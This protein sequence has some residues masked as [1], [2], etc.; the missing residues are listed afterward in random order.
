MNR[1]QFCWFAWIYRARGKAL[2]DVGDGTL[3]TQLRLWAAEST[4][5][6]T[7]LNSK[8]RELKSLLS[9]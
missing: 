2:L 8:A 3:G 6:V 1:E 4:D 7:K 5:I 9:D